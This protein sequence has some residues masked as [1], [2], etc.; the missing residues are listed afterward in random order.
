MY[1]GSGTT[2]IAGTQTITKLCD[3][4]YNHKRIA[5]K[6]KD[7]NNNPVEVHLGYEIEFEFRFTFSSSENA[8]QTKLR[9]ILNDTS[10]VTVT[11]R[12]TY[13]GQLTKAVYTCYLELTSDE[14]KNNVDIITI[15][16]K[17]AAIESIPFIDTIVD[18]D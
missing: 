14:Q 13:N 6:Y 3:I 16:A 17:S 11:P 2:T 4:S 18:P 10:T 5:E 1:L 8:D 15:K 7:I 9:K 12:T